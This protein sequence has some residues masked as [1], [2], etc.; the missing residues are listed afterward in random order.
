MNRHLIRLA[1]ALLFVSAVNLSIMIPGGPVET[2]SFADIS[3][4]IL[5]AFNI[6]LTALGMGSFGLCL[7]VLKGLRPAFFL[8]AL[9]GVGYF[10]VF[11]LDLA[12]I[13]PVSHDRMPPL[14]R[15]LESAGAVLAV[16]LI[17][18][19]GWLSWSAGARQPQSGRPMANTATVKWI[20]VFAALIAIA[21]VIFATFSAMK[22]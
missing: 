12:V 3:P 4:L 18:L 22:A 21:I 19:G 7:F 2:R 11:I 15:V 10:T 9:A 5:T 17:A 14:L 8:C 13:F 6:F 1:A 20:A 16:P